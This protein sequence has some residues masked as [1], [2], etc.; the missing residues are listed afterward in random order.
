[1]RLRELDILDR[2]QYITKGGPQRPQEARGGEF[3]AWTP[4]Q[5]KEVTRALSG[6]MGLLRQS[7]ELAPAY[8][9]AVEK[10]ILEDLGEDLLRF[11][12]NAI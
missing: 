6:L 5:T 7:Q 8:Q 1:M 9:E 12:K 11:L 3:V 10:V 2:S 4:E